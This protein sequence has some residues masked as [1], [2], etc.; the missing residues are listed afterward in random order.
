MVLYKT[1]TNLFS[2]WKINFCFALFNFFILFLSD[3]VSSKLR[4]IR[5]AKGFLSN[6]RV[7]SKFK[8]MFGH[9]GLLFSYIPLIFPRQRSSTER[10]TRIQDPKLKEFVF[11]E[12]AREYY[13]MRQNWNTPDHRTFQFLSLNHSPPLLHEGILWHRAC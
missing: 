6:S 10:L 13:F 3:N 11:R 8:L 12:H 2:L 7:N 4:V 1:L 9:K 5:W